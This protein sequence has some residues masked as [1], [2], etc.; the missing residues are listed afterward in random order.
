MNEFQF[1]DY[2]KENRKWFAVMMPRFVPYLYENGGPI[3]LV[4]VENQYAV[5]GCDR[6]YQHWMRDETLKYVRDKAVLFTND[7]KA[8]KYMKCGKIDGVLATIDFK[9]GNFKIYW[10][11]RFSIETVNQ[12]SIE[13]F[14]F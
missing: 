7:I 8:E 6:V 2:L 13:I 10:T 3:I 5:A 14:A 1:A 4:Q 11:F 12:N 9:A